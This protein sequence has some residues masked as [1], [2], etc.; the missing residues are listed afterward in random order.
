MKDGHVLYTL[1]ALIGLVFAPLLSAAQFVTHQGYDIHYAALLST[2][3]PP[4]VARLHGITRGE[5]QIVIN[6]SALR[7]GHAS[8]ASV[9]GH[10]TNL[11]NQRVTLSFSEVTESDAIYYL[12]SHTALEEDILH[13]EISVT[14]PDTSPVMVR[15]LRRYD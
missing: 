4:D 13:F 2:L 8:H 12:A 9:T 15:F 7:E 1:L 5:N 6:I 14:P 3:I 10:V 11:L